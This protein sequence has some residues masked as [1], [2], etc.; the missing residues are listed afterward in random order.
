[1]D[2][3]SV[4][5]AAREQHHI[6][7]RAGEVWR[8]PSGRTIPPSVQTRLLDVCWTRDCQK[9]VSALSLLALPSGIEPLSP[10]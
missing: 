5:L 8:T 3:P 6:T 2:A 1:M 9:S 7:D 10:P 4:P